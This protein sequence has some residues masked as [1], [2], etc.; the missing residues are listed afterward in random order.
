MKKIFFLMA[1]ASL[2]L[3][4]C[5]NNKTTEHT[6]DENCKHDHEQTDKNASH[7]HGENCNHDHEMPAQES[8]TVEAE[9][10]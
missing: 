2:S 7:T 9:V 8:F 1:V 5:T 3:F 6:H 10:N 4:S